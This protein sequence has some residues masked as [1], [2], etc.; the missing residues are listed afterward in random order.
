[1]PMAPWPHTS[2]KCRWK[3]SENQIN[4]F[5]NEFL[6]LL[7]VQKS[8]FSP[9]D[10]WMFPKIGG[11]PPKSMV[12]MMEN[13]INKWI[14]M[15][16]LGKKKPIFGS[17]P[18]S[19]IPTIYRVLYHPSWLAGFLRPCPRPAPIT[20]TRIGPVIIRQFSGKNITTQWIFQY[21]PEV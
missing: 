5:S 7:M 12:K 15:D 8:I 20:S 16:D 9:V 2:H 14:Q 1:M 13:P 21:P 18:K 6:V 10:K 11:F 19:F 17:T 3:I 4:H